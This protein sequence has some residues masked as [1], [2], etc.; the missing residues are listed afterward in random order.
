[1]LRR[2]NELLERFREKLASRGARGIINLGKSFRVNHQLKFR[3][4]TIITQAV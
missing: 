1:M 3:L 2:L 4:W